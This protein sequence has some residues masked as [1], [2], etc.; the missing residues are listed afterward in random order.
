MTTKI[1]IPSNSSRVLFWCGGERNGVGEGVQVIGVKIGRLEPID[2]IG[3][4]VRVHGCGDWEQSEADLF[5]EIGGF[6]EAFGNEHRLKKG[7]NFLARDRTVDLWLSS[8]AM[9]EGFLDFFRFRCGG[10]RNGVW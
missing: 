3:L 7:K 8:L 9:F 1:H 10:E 2:D 6:E 4:G 5:V